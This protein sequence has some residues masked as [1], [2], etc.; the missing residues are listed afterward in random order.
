LLGVGLLVALFTAL[1]WLAVSRGWLQLSSGSAWSW[2][3]I[4]VLGLVL[5]IGMCWSF[6]RRRLSGQADVDE[7]HGP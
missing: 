6:V 7:V 2:T 1:I 4:L 5:G 3:A